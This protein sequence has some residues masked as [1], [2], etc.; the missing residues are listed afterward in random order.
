MATRRTSKTK[1][2]KSANRLAVSS[3]A[4]LPRPGASARP[5]LNNLFAFVPAFFGWIFTLALFTSFQHVATEYSFWRTVEF[6]FFTLGAAFWVLAFFASMW[7]FGEPRPL[8]VYV[9]G[10]ELTHAFWAWVLGGKVY[11]FRAT[12]A[13]G[14]I[15]TN[16]TNFWIA[17][18][19]YFHPLYSILV[20][21]LYAVASWFYD[22]SAYTPVLFGLLG[23]TW[24][25]HLSFTLWMIPKGQSDLSS[26]G[27]L[28]SLCV[29]YL[30]NVITL[31]LLLIFA[32]PEV[33]FR[34]FG[35]EL[36]KHTIWLV[37]FL[38]NAADTA[39]RAR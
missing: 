9:F 24:A 30:M 21:E 36:S 22:V 25:F 33:T 16:R 23:L 37:S 8:R 29:I 1:K 32:S 18:T 31:A 19:P 39:L 12:R 17:L 28:F 27:T 3:A 7:T 11:R 20:I 38:L 13:G 14:Y 6:Q 2:T 15:E 10:H 5:W 35:H 26:H 34:S 4:A